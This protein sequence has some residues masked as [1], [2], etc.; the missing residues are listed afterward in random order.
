M[1]FSDILNLLKNMGVILAAVFYVAIVFWTY[2]DM[3]KR[4]DDPILIATATAV[5]MLPI[6]GVL[7]YL[8]LRP[9]EY[10]ADVRERELEIR[11]MEREL[12]RH[13]RCPYCKSHIEA[14]YLSCPVCTT[15][16]RQ[17]CVTCDKP[18]DP[19][20]VLCPFCETE[21]AGRARPAT[22]TSGGSNAAAGG[23]RGMSPRASAGRDR[24]KE[25][26]ARVERP[27][28]SRDASR[29]NERSTTKSERSTAKPGARDAGATTS[30]D[31]R[32]GIST[33]PF[34]SE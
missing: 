17:S 6:V 5:S 24:S 13:E 34:T 1:T 25:R 10:L 29:S 14:G 31:D 19:R 21:V 15:K 11:V 20:W 4:S 3:R 22:P 7:V 28:R 16:L 2:K 12:G 26:E 18:L 8:L 32:A 9:S 30:T 33:E 23:A 27:S